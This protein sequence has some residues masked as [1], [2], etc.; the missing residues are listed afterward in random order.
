MMIMKYYFEVLKPERTSNNRYRIISYI[1][2]IANVFTMSK[3]RKGSEVI[4]AKLLHEDWQ[5][6]LRDYANKIYLDVPSEIGF[7][8]IAHVNGEC[9]VESGQYLAKRYFSMKDACT[10]NN[11]NV[12]IDENIFK[13]ENV[14]T[15]DKN[16]EH[17]IVNR[18]YSYALYLDDGKT[19]D[20]EVTL[21]GKHR[22]NIATLA[23][24]LMMNSSINAELKNRPVYEK[25]EMLEEKIAEIDID[26]VI[27]SVT[28]QKHYYLIKKI[29]HDESKYPRQ[30]I[31]ETKTKK[32]RREI[33]KSYYQTYFEDEFALLTE[34]LAN[35][36]KVF[37]SELEYKLK[38]IGF[39]KEGDLFLYDHD[40]VFA[41]VEAAIDEKGRKV[42]VSA[43]LY[44][45][46]YGEK[47][48]NEEYAELL[49]RVIDDLTQNL[50]KEPEIHSSNEWGGSEDESFVFSIE[51]EPD[52]QN[53]EDFLEV[54]SDIS[55]SIA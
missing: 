3:K 41:N 9:T 14:S 16:I 44:N 36:D 27:P 33:L 34:F 8:K 49:S 53:I 4:A 52:I 19:V 50:G 31:S 24:Y 39:Y 42:I 29:M 21:P 30:K 47:N 10:W 45:P 40:S 35:E 32:E 20:I 11:G 13:N 54:L 37:V 12:C 7:N 6:T 5:K 23:N 15:G 55:E 38:K 17:F 22:K 25:I 26:Y 48:D 2:I 28:C 43:E 51:Y 1:N 46:T 18:G